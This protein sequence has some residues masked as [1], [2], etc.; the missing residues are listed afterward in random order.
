MVEMNAGFDSPDERDYQYDMLFGSET[1]EPIKFP[2]NELTVQNQWADPITHMACSR[3]GIVHISNGQF[4]LNMNAEPYDGKRMWE[5]Y[6]LANPTA[7]K[8]GATL[9]SALTQAKDT[10]MIAGY[11]TIKTI[12]EAKQALDRGHFIYTGSSNGNW[13]A[14]RNTKN[15]EIRTDNQVIGHIW[16]I[17][18]YNDSGFTAIN[19]YGAENGY[20]HFPYNLFDTT[21]TKYAVIPIREYDYFQ[22]KLWE[23]TMNI[24][25]INESRKRLWLEPIAYVKGADGTIYKNTKK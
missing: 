6:L 7:E 23:I 12:D 13:N 4:L 24:D 8:N 21:F 2:I 15:Y 22:E 3:F 19:S 1:I 16:S 14:V 20:F 25:K 5:A 9:Q 18:G 17:I 11:A 10:G